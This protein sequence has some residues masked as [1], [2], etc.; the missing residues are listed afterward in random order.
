MNSLNESAEVKIRYH[1]EFFN[2]ENYIFAIF[3][4]HRLTRNGINIRHILV[5]N[6]NCTCVTK[7]NNMSEQ[8]A[9]LEK[10]LAK[11]KFILSQKASELHDLIE[12]RLPNNYQDI[13]SYAEATF[14]AGLEWDRIRKQLA[15]AKQNL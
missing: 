7:T 5:W 9:D 12:D 6:A 2:V 11:A 3:E 10:A 14:Q 8:I 15:E 1:L 13:P 4:T